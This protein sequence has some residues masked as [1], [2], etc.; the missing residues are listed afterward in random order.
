VERND[1]LAV[2]D[3]VRAFD[4]ILFP[5]GADIEPK[6]YREPAHTSAGPFD[7]ELDEGQFALAR[8]VL[9]DDIPALWI[10]RGLQLLGVAAGAS[11]YQDL[12]SERPSEI[13]HNPKR[14]KDHLAHEVEIV[15]GSRLAG[16]AGETRFRVNSRHHQA[17]REASGSDA[18]GRFAVVA[19]APDG[20]IEGLEGPGAR[21]R[22]AVQWHPENLVPA[23]QPSRGLFAAFLAACR[24]GRSSSQGVAPSRPH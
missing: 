17:V 7:P 19:R 11:L 14:P 4:G 18:I 13:D 2:R 24:P 6:H 8:H 22:I 15:A 3:L 1:P 5:G 21:F 20:V 16:A 9:E 10:C 12:P 23:H